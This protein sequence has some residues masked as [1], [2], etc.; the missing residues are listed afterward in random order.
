MP[1]RALFLTLPL[2]LASAPAFAADP[3]PS[4]DLRGFHAPADH[5]SGL[6]LEPASSPATFDWSA[7]LWLSYATSPIKLVDA[8]TDETAFRVIRHQVSGI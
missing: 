1:R 7:A 4:L 2:V 6:Y 5:G 3:V 8:R